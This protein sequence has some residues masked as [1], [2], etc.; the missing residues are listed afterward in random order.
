MVKFFSLFIL[1]GLVFE[2]FPIHAGQKDLSQQLVKFERAAKKI[3]AAINKDIQNNKKTT[4]QRIVS[5]IVRKTKTDKEAMVFFAPFHT[6]SGIPIARSTANFYFTKFEESFLRHKSSTLKFLRSDNQRI[7]N[8]QKFKK[9]KYLITSEIELRN[10]DLTI[11]FRTSN[12]GISI[13][14]DIVRIFDLSSK[15]LKVTKM[16]AMPDVISQAAQK[17]ADYGKAPSEQGTRMKRLYWDYLS[18]GRHGNSTPFGRT[19]MKQLAVDI[20]E[21]FVNPL[22]GKQLITKRLPQRKKALKNGDFFLSGSTELFGDK[23][24]IF[25]ELSDQKS[26]VVSSWAGVIDRRTTGK[27]TYEGRSNAQALKEL[28]TLDKTRAIELKLTIP[29]AGESSTLS[30]GEKWNL[31]VFVN[32]P[33]WIYCYY[34]F[35]NKQDP[36]K[37]KTIMIFP[38]PVTWSEYKTPR[39]P[40]Q[41]IISIPRS[42]HSKN[43]QKASVSFTAS[44]PIGT[45]LVKCFASQRDITMDLPE[46][47]RGKEIEAN[48]LPTLPDQMGSMLSDIFRDVDPM[49]SESSLLITVIKAHLR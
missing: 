21:R 47:L 2:P 30:I 49:I 20:Q 41:K 7:R 19:L 10:R 43:T 9:S 35:A 4:A 39:I 1:L 12:D 18:D 42:A 5:A 24:D 45:E 22:T 27:L 38:N 8:N 28:K 15:D 6:V 29:T 11:T 34:F 32:K 44:P 48:S 26:Q 3:A 14:T 37:N 25:L 23:I 31:G 13:S 16:F 17:F 36:E 46:E 33:A 40:P